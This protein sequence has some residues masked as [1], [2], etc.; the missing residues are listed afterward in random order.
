VAT[1]KRIIDNTLARSNNYERVVREC[2]T[3]LYNTRYGHATYTYKHTH[4]YTRVYGVIESQ[5]GGGLAN[6]LP[7][8]FDAN[9]TSLATNRNRPTTHGRFAAQRQSFS[10]DVYRVDF[11]VLDDVD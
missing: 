9:D 10:P 4:T 2:R 11:R 3:H 5:V 6:K 7:T 1:R 8:V